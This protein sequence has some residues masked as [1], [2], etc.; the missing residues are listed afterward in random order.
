[1]KRRIFVHGEQ[2]HLDE[3]IAAAIVI[4]AFPED[5]FTV[6]RDSKAWVDA[7]PTDFILDVG[8]KYDGKRLFDHHQKELPHTKEN[9]SECAATLVA[10]VFAPWMLSDPRMATMLEMV[11]VLDTM[12]PNEFRKRYFDLDRYAIPMGL[13]E[14]FEE[15][16]TATARA[17]AK[18]IAKRKYTGENMPQY[19]AWVKANSHRNENVL[20]LDADPWQHYP[21][22]DDR[23]V[24][25]AMTRIAEAEDDV[26][27]YGYH[28]RNPGNRSLFRTAKGENDG[29]D[30]THAKPQNETFTHANG[31]LQVFIPADD[32]EYIH[33]VNQS[34]PEQ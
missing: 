33:L 9:G 8:E 25:E 5:D 3:T 22:R 32:E 21:I 16:P 15:E 12:G 6:V 28:R 34:K 13:A 24:T 30:L 14:M 26:M 10:K 23:G 20:V 11:R 18:V 7:D 29:Y 1:M 2:A 19:K 27:I 4:V 31:F 17:F